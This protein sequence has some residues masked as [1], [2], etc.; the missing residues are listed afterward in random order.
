MLI[1]RII[2]LSAILI[3]PSH[4]WASGSET[5]DPFSSIFMA[6]AII[7]FTALAGRFIANKLK[8]STVLGELVM[9]IALGTLLMSL[10]RPIMHVIRNQEVV[11]EVI[12]RIEAEDKPISIAVPEVLSESTLPETEKV[13]VSQV[14]T[15]HE[16]TR[17]ISLSR[18]IQ[19]FSTIGISML[20]F[21]VGLE[22]SIKDLISVGPRALVVALLGV[23]VSMGLGFLTLKLLLS[24]TADPRLAFFGAATIASTSAGI[25][26]RVLK[27]LN[28]LSTPEA[29]ITMGAA[30]FDDILGL[31]LLAVLANIM[32]SGDMDSSSIIWIAGKIIL[33]LIAA[34]IFG[35]KI[36]PRII[37]AF[38]KLDQ[39]SIKLIFPLILMLLMCYL[40]NLIGLAMIIGA[41]FAGLM[42][43]EEQFSAQPD[44]HHSTI[45]SLMAPIEGIFVPVF[46]VLMGLQVDVTL[47]ADLNVIGLGLALSAVAILGK[48]GAGIFLPSHYKKIAVGWGMVPRGEVV[49]IF[50]S[51]GKAMGIITPQF[52]A[53]V[54]MVILIT[55]L[56]S[57]LALM[58][59]YQSVKG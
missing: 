18:Y 31:I 33:F 27:D 53:S 30:V 25:T 38:E 22:G 17:Y 59:T 55:V 32:V 21:M 42:L 50:A 34:V 6:Y 54:V 56:I 37:P 10:D 11:Q 15:S 29:K 16:A 43:M 39:K 52:Y 44:K 45:E 58:R 28:R 8:Q 9:G 40:A 4:A 20:L 3:I 48:L 14:L 2:I 23:G 12:L 19:L 7:L 49:L 36:L 41:Y 51:I 5:G 13:A 47:F 57:P 26:A 1:R 24:S 46:F 35:L